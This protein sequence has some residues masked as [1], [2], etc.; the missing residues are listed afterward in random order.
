ML[1]VGLDGLMQ[2]Q[3]CLLLGEGIGD[4]SYIDDP[5]S[6]PYPC[7]LVG[8]EDAE[9]NLDPYCRSKLLKQV[10]SDYVIRASTATEKGFITSEEAWTFLAESEYAYSSGRLN[11]V[12]LLESEGAAA[13]AVSGP[14]PS[15]VV[16][17]V[18]IAA[19][20]TK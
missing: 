20:A 14:G 13:G 3:L 12:E 9:E 4:E 8:P 6:C 1:A 11:D 10:L 17:A 15:A 19:I 2:D 5:R 18:L 16:R 7:A